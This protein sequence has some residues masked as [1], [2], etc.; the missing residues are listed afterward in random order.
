MGFDAA[1]TSPLDFTFRPHLD[2]TGTIPDPTDAEVRAFNVRIERLRDELRTTVDAADSDKDDQD[3]D[4]IAKAEE[5]AARVQEQ[6][7]DTVAELCKGT[8]TREQIDQL[9]SRVQTAFL[10]W[11][12]GE[13]RNPTKLPAIRPPLAAVR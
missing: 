13:L 3:G 10:E 9:P 2:V 6:M 11:L 7:L 4:Q 5:I 12:I 1:T 8:P